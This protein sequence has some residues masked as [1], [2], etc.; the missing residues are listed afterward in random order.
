MCKLF[1]EMLTVSIYKNAKT[2]FLIHS[3]HAEISVDY[4]KGL[5]NLK[6]KKKHYGPGT[7]FSIGKVGVN[8][9]IIIIL[10][11]GNV[12]IGNQ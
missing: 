6:K 12:C 9:Y 10:F 7:G 3:G 4:I 1:G 5:V 11:S 8:M 2:Q